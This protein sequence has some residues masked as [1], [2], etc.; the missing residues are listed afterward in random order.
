[1]ETRGVHH[2]TGRISATQNDISA[3]TQ[4]N[5]YTTTHQDFAANG[6]GGDETHPLSGQ[7]RVANLVREDRV[8]AEMD[9]GATKGRKPS[10]RARAKTVSSAI[11]WV[12]VCFSSGWVAG[13]RTRSW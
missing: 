8:L 12:R 13:P 2:S 3:E 4:R 9:P 11:L 6:G 5:K 7:R 10:E 1:M